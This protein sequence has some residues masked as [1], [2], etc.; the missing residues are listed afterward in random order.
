MAQID[1]K[2][3]VLH[4]QDGYKGPGGTGL[5]NLMAGYM[6][7]AATMTVDGFVGAVA[8]GDR[9]TVAGDTVAVSLTQDSTTDLVIHTI[10]AHTE[11]MSNTTSITFAPALTNS[12]TDDAVITILPHD[13]VVIMGEGNLTWTEKKNV[14]YKKNRGLLRNVRLGDQEPVEVKMDFLWELLTST[15]GAVPTVREALKQEG[16]AAAWVTAGADPC[17]PYAVNLVVIYTPPCS[18]TLIETYYLTEFRFEELDHDLKAGT[19]AVSGHCNNLEV[20]ALRG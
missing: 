8:V 16:N 6:A 3:A 14:E 1:L 17:E 20:T 7:A 2:Y 18:A 11:T 12:V 5:V 13:L 9:F 10:S 4:V 15:S 19:V